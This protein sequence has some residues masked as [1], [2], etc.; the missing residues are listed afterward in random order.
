MK[1]FLIAAAA[2][3]ILLFGP[4]AYSEY[5]MGLKMDTIQ[6]EADKSALPFKV[7][8]PPTAPVSRLTNYTDVQMAITNDGVVYYY[9]KSKYEPNLM[10]LGSLTIIQHAYIENSSSG[11][12]VTEKNGQKYFYMPYGGFRALSHYRNTTYTTPTEIIM[13]QAGEKK[14][15]DLG[16]EEPVYSKAMIA[17]AESMK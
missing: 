3:L 7:F 13:M 8:R 16:G 5:Q 6:K 15:I 12:F 17:I 9:G 2:I 10:E 11:G 4:L 1:K 14:S